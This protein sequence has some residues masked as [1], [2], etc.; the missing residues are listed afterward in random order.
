MEEGAQGWGEFVGPFSAGK[1]TPLLE[2]RRGVCFCGYF[3]AKAN[4]PS[5]AEKGGLLSAILQLPPHTGQN[6]AKG[7]GTLAGYEAT[8][9]L[10]YPT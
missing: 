8:S 5:R 3:A 9:V 2:P 4:P 6:H 7:T 1:Q 10:L